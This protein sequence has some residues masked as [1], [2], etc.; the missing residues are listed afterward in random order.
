MKKLL[1]L[2]ALLAC[3][4]IPSFA[5]DGTNVVNQ[6]D[7][8]MIEDLR[9]KFNALQDRVD[10]LADESNDIEVAALG[11]L[12]QTVTDGATV[13]ASVDQDYTPTYAGQILVYAESNIVWAADGETT[14]DW[15]QLN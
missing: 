11:T 4:A 8:E 5:Q 14:N 6:R 9:V 1:A 12:V 7:S 13:I 15:I 2:V 10:L 3:F